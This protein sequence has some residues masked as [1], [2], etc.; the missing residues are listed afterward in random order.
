MLQTEEEIRETV[1]SYIDSISKIDT[2]V[3][4]ISEFGLSLEFEDRSDYTE[5]KSDTLDSAEDELKDRLE[6]GLIAIGD[7]D[8]YATCRVKEG[9]RFDSIDKL[10][11]ARVFYNLGNQEFMV[12]ELLSPK[13]K[14][15]GDW[16]ERIEKYL[17]R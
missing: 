15:K 5:L 16:A 14:P 10:Y 8:F 7:A 4:D 17:N 12:N 2:S 3:R 1:D 11:E 9:S 13:Y 6:R